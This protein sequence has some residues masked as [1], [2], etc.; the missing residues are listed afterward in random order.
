MG[1]GDD[2][3]VPQAAGDVI[4]GIVEE[5]DEAHLINGAGTSLEMRKMERQRNSGMLSEGNKAGRN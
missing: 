4:S 2:V 1:H 5:E 3:R